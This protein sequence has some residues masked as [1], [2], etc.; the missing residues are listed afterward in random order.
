VAPTFDHDD[1]RAFFRWRNGVVERFD[2]TAEG[3][4]LGWVA[5]QVLDFKWGYLGGDVQRWSPADVREILLE[6][7]PRKVVL[8]PGDE[9]DVVDG[10]RALVRFLTAEGVLDGGEAAARRLDDAIGAVAGEFPRAMA[11][12]ARWGMGKR[13]MSGA[14]ASGFDPTDQ[15]GLEAWMDHFNQLPRAERD[16]ILGTTPGEPTRPAGTGALVA[17]GPAGR[18]RTGP[19]V[20]PLPPITLPP[21]N[22]LRSAARAS[23]WA[24]RVR[25]LAAFVGDGRPL[26]DR[27]N[28]KLADGKV[29]VG[30]LGT[31]DRV[32]QTIGDHTYKTRSSA[33]L[34]G[35]DLTFRLACAAGVLAGEGSKVRPGP[36][37][38]L[39]ADD[40]D[41]LELAEAVLWAMLDHVGPARHHWRRDTYGFGWFAEDVD[42]ALPGMLL[43]LYRTG[44]PAPIDELGDEMWDTLLDAYVLD[45]VEQRKLDHHH[46]LVRWAVR[47]AFER[48]EELGVVTTTGVEERPDPWGITTERLGGEV[49]LTPLGLWALQRMASAFTD[50]PVAGTLADRDVAGL[51]RAAADLPDDLARAEIDAWV[52]RRDDAADQLA[53]ALPGLDATA[54]GLGFRA[55]LTLGPA[56][57]GAV[58]RLASHDELE[59][60]VTVW[61]AHDSAGGAACGDGGDGGHDADCGGDPERFV[62]LLGAVQELWGSDA[63]A[64]WL[65]RVAGVAG[66]TVMIGAAWRVRRPET[67]AALA[68]VGA[69][70]PDKTVA[71]AARKALHKHRTSRAAG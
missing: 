45:D 38:E 5:S 56:A 40:A 4:K 10:F 59:P 11:D 50:A 14:A 41:P 64:G 9:A 21:P 7:Y 29:L 46:D 66:P 2:R 23:V 17:V 67:E 8:E 13:L 60:W 49:A 30:L 58:D 33:D 54:R 53:A 1:E 69:T 12:E 47:R 65:D 68:A 57:R 32:D 16:R 27:G 35:V 71:K 34:P 3:A 26:T 36:R 51:L 6:L 44:A 31:A 19:T 48:L 28:L 18:R 25:R 39:V 70:H 15:A 42:A 24:D 63:I 62:R 20:P 55:L 43:D 22:E 52:A 61:R 37:V